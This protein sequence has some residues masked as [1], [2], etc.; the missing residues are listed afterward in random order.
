M[1]VLLSLSLASSP[2]RDV[3]GIT[4]DQG[5]CY[6]SIGPGLGLALQKMCWGLWWGVLQSQ[7]CL[8][9]LGMSPS[10]GSAVQRRELG[11]ENFIIGSFGKL[12]PYV[13][14]K[15]SLARALPGAIRRDEQLF[16]AGDGFLN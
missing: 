13:L 10:Q 8:H 5:G 6:S 4:Q 7:Q 9:S 15:L 1:A 16:S 3:G 14:L 11:Q 12:L 2:V